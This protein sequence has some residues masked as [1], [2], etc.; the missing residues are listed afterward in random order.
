MQMS[1]KGHENLA[2]RLA[3]KKKLRG[4]LLDELNEP[5]PSE[6]LEK[7]IHIL[8]VEITDLSMEFNNEQINATTAQIHGITA[9]IHG[10]TA[11][12]HATTAQIHATT[13]QEKKND[14][15][16]KKKDLQDE[17]NDLQDEKKRLD[18]EKKRLD[19][20]KKR[21]HEKEILLLQSQS[22]A[23]QGTCLIPHLH[24]PMLSEVRWA[25]GPGSGGSGTTEGDA[26]C[27]SC[28]P[29]SL[30]KSSLTISLQT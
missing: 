21:L 14:L 7:R 24:P 28:C 12:I 20:E 26:P 5:H 30:T 10:I 27:S 19:D 4:E 8:N 1:T 3:R 9:Q 18:D 25:S 11:Q 13:D 6:D 2:A 23:T 17:K 22:N 16:E 15:Q 29:P